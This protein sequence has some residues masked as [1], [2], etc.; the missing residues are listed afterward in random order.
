MKGRPIMSHFVLCPLRTAA[1]KVQH[2]AIREAAWNREYPRRVT[3]AD[4]PDS[5]EAGSP[6]APRQMGATY[7]LGRFVIA[8]LARMVYR[9]RVE[10]RENVPRSGPTCNIRPSAITIS[11]STT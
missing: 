3:S 2:E 6:L 8:P 11:S 7:G 5:T 10:G 1:W 9:P 4:A